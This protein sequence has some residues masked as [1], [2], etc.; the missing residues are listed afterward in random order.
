MHTTLELVVKT[1]K[2]NKFLIIF[3]VRVKSKKQLAQW[4]THLSAEVMAK[5][6]VM[7]VVHVPQDSLAGVKASANE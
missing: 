1:E 4:T 2:H 5:H 3:V 7:L 6:T